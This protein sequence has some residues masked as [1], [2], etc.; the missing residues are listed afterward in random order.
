MR[1]IRV[2][3]LKSWWGLNQVP[4]SDGKTP[5]KGATVSW[6]SFVFLRWFGLYG[7]TSIWSE[8]QT[9]RD[10]LQYKMHSAPCRKNIISQWLQGVEMYYW[11]CVCGRIH[12][13]CTPPPQ[14]GK[15]AAGL[16]SC[17]RMEPCPTQPCRV[18]CCIRHLLSPETACNRNRKEKKI[19]FF[20]L[21]APSRHQ[22]NSAAASWQQLYDWLVGRSQWANWGFST[23][24]A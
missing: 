9:K 10:M 6:R 19:S 14:G 20:P 23:S 15:K 22:V 13:A 2:C 7:S 11:A 21:T 17:W 5:D 3:V 1:R 18:A 4:E 24:E 16:T 8:T 12:R